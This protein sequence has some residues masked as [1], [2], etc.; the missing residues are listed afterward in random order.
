MRLNSLPYYMQS[1][2]TWVGWLQ[3]RK[4][5]H[6]KERKECAKFKC[7]F[8]LQARVEESPEKNRRKHL[9]KVHRLGSCRLKALGHSCWCK[10]ITYVI[11]KDIY[12]VRAC[13]KLFA[14]WGHGGKFLSRLFMHFN[15]SLASSNTF[16]LQL[17]CR[18]PCILVL[19]DEQVKSSLANFT[20][21]ILTFCL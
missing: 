13:D 2:K 16:M 6:S 7:D 18:L 20:L 4:V 8:H 19:W 12:R 3:K 21:T 10:M 17:W 5:E 11:T 14:Y 1:G 15:Y 9:N